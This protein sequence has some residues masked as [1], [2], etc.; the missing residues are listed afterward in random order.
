[1]VEA[2]SIELNL[3]FIAK[4]RTLST[5][6]Y[7]L[8][9]TVTTWLPRWAWRTTVRATVLHYH[10][11]PLPGGLDGVRRRGAAGVGK[12]RR[13]RT[14]TV[15]ITFAQPAPPAQGV[16][17]ADPGERLVPEDGLDSPRSSAIVISPYG[18]GS[19]ST[20]G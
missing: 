15:G 7:A 11:R 19:Y 8:T 4:P 12:D 5:A 16:D 10:P 3:I 1:M 13:A 6:A 20:S 9:I 2:G 17:R 18:S 14:D